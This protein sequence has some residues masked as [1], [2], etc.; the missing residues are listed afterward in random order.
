METRETN[1]T[2]LWSFESIF[3]GKS[4]K[5]VIS[6]WSAASYWGFSPRIDSKIFITYPKGYN[7][8][9]KSSS[10]IKK[11]RSGDLYSKDIKHIMFDDKNMN[12]YSPERTIVELIKDAKGTF[13]DV[14][15]ETIKNFFNVVNYKYAVVIEWAKKF[16]I[17]G[18]VKAF[19][20]M[21]NG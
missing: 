10:I 11:Q 20:A 21:N 13:N 7:P 16:K 9:L 3:T 19:F 2:V 6:S 4:N 12:V 17:E 8:N 14:L 5:G 18:I 15:V 1:T